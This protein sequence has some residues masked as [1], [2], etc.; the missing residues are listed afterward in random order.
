MAE[1]RKK[2]ELQH[3]VKIGIT[4]LKRQCC[5]IYI[6]RLEALMVREATKMLFRGNVH[7]GKGTQCLVRAVIVF[8]LNITGPFYDFSTLIPGL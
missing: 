2:F 8:R 5:R 7:N 6:L 4:K 1:A 3:F